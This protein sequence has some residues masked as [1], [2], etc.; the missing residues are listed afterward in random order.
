MFLDNDLVEFCRRLPNRFKLRN[1]ER[2]YLLKQV[3]RRL[4]PSAIIDRKKKGFGIPLGK[5]LREVPAEPPLSPLP[6][7]RTDYVRRAFTAHRTGAADHRLFLWSWLAAQGF[8]G[9]MTPAAIAAAP[10]T[11]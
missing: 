3:A 8:A 11:G 1:G 6:D 10:S 9:Q 5:W 4:L 7:M 2:K